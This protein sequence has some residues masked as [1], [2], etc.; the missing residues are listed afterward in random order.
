MQIRCIVEGRGDREAVPVLIRHIAKTLDPAVVVDV[1][2]G[3]PV[4]RDRLLREGELERAVNLAAVQL[5][6]PGAVLVVIDSEGSPPCTLAPKLLQRATTARPD[7]PV[8]VVLAH[9]EFEAWF[10]AAAESLRGHRGLSGDLTPPPEPESIQ[11]AKE[12]LR[13]RMPLARKYRETIDQP[14]LAAVMDLQMARRSKSFD[15]FYREVCRLIG[16][17]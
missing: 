12:W 5:Q 16:T 11:G 13:K 7:V 10:L 17:P 6:R 8:S 1:P 15:K 2:L 9:R 4:P 14:A 3:I